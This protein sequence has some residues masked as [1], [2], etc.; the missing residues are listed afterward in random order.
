MRTA[1]AAG[2]GG[3]IADWYGP[4]TYSDVVFSNMV[5][6]AERCGFSVAICLEEKSFFPGYSQAATRGE[7]Q[8]VMVRQ[9]RHVLG[10]HAKSPSYFRR[11]GRPVFFIFN[12]FEDGVLGRH[13]LT[14]D[15]VALVLAIVPERILLAS[16]HYDTNYFS[17][18]RGAYAWVGDAKY[19]SAFYEATGAA[20]AS[21]Q[22]ELV[23]GVANPG[24]DDTPVWGWGRGPR[25]TDRRGTLEYEKQW[26]DVLKYQ[27]ELVQV[28]TWNDFEEGTTIEPA[29][30]YGFT[31]VNR[32]EEY[33]GRL[34]GRPV[35][36]SDNEAP[37]RRFQA[38]KQ[39]G[40]K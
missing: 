1:Q 40:E 16:Q 39:N 19:R 8:D 36:L 37:L 25:V 4:D 32:T 38:L 9:L 20:R 5:R 27:P 12:N 33:V 17:M 24:F 14:P 34:N 22:L 30:P 6:V 28:V 13:E 18:V 23:A 10:S 35:D 2:I 29:D 26:D 31:F 15:E 7:A 3:F 11:A 21:G